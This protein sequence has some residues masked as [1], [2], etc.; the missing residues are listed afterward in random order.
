MDKLLVQHIKQS[1]ETSCGA[2]ALSMVYQYFKKND[3]T[4]KVIWERLKKSRPQVPGQ[5]YLETTDMAIDSQK[6]GFCYFLAQAVLDSSD[7][8]LQ[9]IKEFLSLSIPIIVCQKLSESNILGHFRVVIGID[10]KNIILNDPMEEKNETI[11]DINRFMTLWAKT[12]N[13]EV[14]G[15]QFLAIFKK[16]QIAK[17]S[18]FKIFVFN[19]NIKYFD[20]MSLEFI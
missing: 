16:E 7:L 15:G 6:Q 14:I 2:A 20:A 19:S 4:E 8:A 3:Q 10:E 17:E 13:G 18:R 1:M 5:Y 11:I 12:E 9:P